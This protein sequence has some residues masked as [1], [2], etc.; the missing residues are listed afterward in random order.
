M[1]TRHA[2]GCA[3]GMS[4]KTRMYFSVRYG[5]SADRN[6]SV[7]AMNNQYA[8]VPPCRSCREAGVCM[9]AIRVREE[10]D[11]R[12]REYSRAWRQIK[13]PCGCY[14]LPMD[15]LVVFGEN[16]ERVQCNKH[17]CQVLTPKRR[18]SMTKQAEEMQAKNKP[19]E[20]VIPNDPYL[21]D[22][23]PF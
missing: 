20:D 14:A 2:A 16:I 9:K 5:H 1:S 22:I 4:I 17:G 15:I 7:N 13:L 11:V 8:C 18:K 10:E 19:V 3:T 23:P 6:A 21:F 12:A